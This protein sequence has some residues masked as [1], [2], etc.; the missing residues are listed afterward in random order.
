MRGGSFKRSNT[1]LTKENYAEFITEL[2]TLTLD[3]S[4]E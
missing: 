2:N 3:V 1:P 4:D